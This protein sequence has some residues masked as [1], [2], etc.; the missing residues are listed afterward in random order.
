MRS[1]IFNNSFRVVS[2]LPRAGLATKGRIGDYLK[3]QPNSVERAPN[4]VERAPN[5][6]E[7]APNLVEKG[8]NIGILIKYSKERFGDNPIPQYG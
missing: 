6:V 1:Y 4:L 2:T 7:R 3:R 8:A 5:L